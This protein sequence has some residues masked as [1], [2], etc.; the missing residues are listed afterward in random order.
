LAGAATVVPLIA[1]LDAGIV[2]TVSAGLLMS[3]A[4]EK[5]GRPGAIRL[6]EGMLPGF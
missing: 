3:D 5:A 6:A 1:G 2:G 4:P